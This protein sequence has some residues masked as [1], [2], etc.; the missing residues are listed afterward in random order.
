MPTILR[1]D[2]RYLEIAALERATKGGAFCK[3]CMDGDY[4]V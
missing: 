4:P 1:D 2:L 3:A